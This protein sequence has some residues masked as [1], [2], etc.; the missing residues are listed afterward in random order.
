[1]VGARWPEEPLYL[2]VS[3]KLM[4]SASTW[5]ESYERATTPAQRTL[6]HFFQALRERYGTK[7]DEVEAVER[8]AARS[9]RVGET[10]AEYAAA[11]RR[12]VEG[13]D[14]PEKNFVSAFLKGLSPTTGPLI[15]AQNPTDLNAAVYAAVLNMKHDGTMYGQ[16]LVVDA[17]LVEGCGNEFIVGSDFWTSKRATINYETAEV[18][19]P[20]KGGQVIVPFS[21][22]SAGSDPP[23]RIVRSRKLPTESQ[24][25]LRLRVP[26][27][28]GDVGFFVP[29]PTTRAH[30][31][32]ATT[33]TRVDQGEIVVPVL[34]V[35]GKRV[36]L[37]ARSSLG[38]WVPC[39]KDMEVLE[40]E[41]ELQKEAVSEWLATLRTG[42]ACGGGPRLDLDT[43]HLDEGQGRLLRAV[44]ES[45]PRVVTD[46]KVCP[47]PTD[48]GVEHHIP[49][50]SAAPIR[51]R[52]WRHAER[53]RETIDRHVDE[54]LRAGV[55]EMGQGPWCFPVVLVK[56]KDGSV[57]FC[58][59]YRE[60]NNVTVK[61]VY[62]LPRIDDTLES[63]GGATRFTTLDLMAGYWQVPVAENDRDKTA[64]AT[65]RENFGT[66]AEPLTRLLRK[67]EEWRWEDEQQVAF[68]TLKDELSSKPTLC[69][70]DFEKPFVLAT[71][72]S[73]KGLGAVLM[74]DQ[75]Q[76][77]QPIGYASKVTNEQQ[78]N[79]PI[80]HLE[81]LAVVW[82]IQHFRPYLYGREFE[83][84]T[85][86]AALKWLMTARE[87][88]R[89][90]HRWAL[91]L[92]EYNFTVVYRPGKT[93][94]VPDALSR[95]PVGT[96]ERFNRTWKDMVSMYVEEDQRDWDE[97]LSLMAYAYNSAVNTVTGFTPM[98]LLTGREPRAPRDLLL[99]GRREAIDDL[100]QWHRKMKARMLRAEA[101]ARELFVE[102][103]RKVVRNDSGRYEVRVLVEV[104]SGASLGAK[105]W[106]SFADYEKFWQENKDIE[107]DVEPG[108]GE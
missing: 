87:L 72:A 34:N 88:E 91:A 19:Y 85:D 53:E 1:M 65:R 60:L 49:T 69:Y 101:L 6:D 67:K 93:N 74:Q 106:M 58:I 75:G 5:A 57:R 39:D 42:A 56:K 108:Q 105:Q 94:V 2:L 107:D 104:L 70:P 50:G 90:L 35:L 64:F 15:R 12:L 63:L 82:A 41:G 38:R 10:Y 9:K 33:L 16:E 13:V 32:M 66:K 22:V 54:M 7:L 62:P 55:I 76:G 47:P 100:P 26:A 43:S 18:T 78:S 95:A 97:W 48:T 86:H 103:A 4:G 23:V 27:A 14:I 24:S 45:F 28:S 20:E 44:L 30:L 81:C 84:V 29:T 25:M 8:L 17:L 11:L 73:I 83:V 79:Y 31:L 3:S 68:Q 51:I 99:P 96:V 98:E 46:E 80:T 21:C 102:L 92:Q 61:D 89:R 71:D 37:P 36:K 59:D 77:L 40:N 52:R